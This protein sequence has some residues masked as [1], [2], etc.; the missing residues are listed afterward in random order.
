MSAAPERG[1][2]PDLTRH[3]HS[4]SGI[5]GTAGFRDV[6]AVAAAV[7][8]LLELLPR[9]EVAA[10][11]DPLRRAIAGLATMVAEVHAM[12]VAAG[13]ARSSSPSWS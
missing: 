12:Q 13:A 6:R 8:R 11:L 10:N 3:I 1:V 9:D 4:L 2:P 5:S 7:E